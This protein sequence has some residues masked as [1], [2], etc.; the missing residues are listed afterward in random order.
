M[1]GKGGSGIQKMGGE[2]R[3]GRVGERSGRYQKGYQ[4]EQ[5]MQFLSV[6]ILHDLRVTVCVLLIRQ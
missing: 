6:I 1:G 4:H 3:G 2:D 5:A